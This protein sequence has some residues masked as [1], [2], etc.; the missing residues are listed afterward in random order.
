MQHDGETG[1]SGGTARNADSEGGDGGGS[2]D[3]GAHLGRAGSSVSSSESNTKSALRETPEYENGSAAALEKSRSSASP[4]LPLSTQKQQQDDDAED[5]HH[6]TS[7]QRRNARLHA[8]VH[9]I[10][11]RLRSQSN[12]LPSPPSRVTRWASWFAKLC[13]EELNFYVSLQ[14][15][16]RRALFSHCATRRSAGKRQCKILPKRVAELEH[17]RARTGLSPSGAV[18]GAVSRRRCDAPRKTGDAAVHFI[19]PS[20]SVAPRWRSAIL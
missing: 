3:A 17:T 15:G 1:S 12:L 20:A 13:S 7:K 10:S 6:H 5:E 18:S 11:D 4:P 16:G 14:R 19:A 8:T 2:R 9:S